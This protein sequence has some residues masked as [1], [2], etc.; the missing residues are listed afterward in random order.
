MHEEP[1]YEEIRKKALELYMTDPAHRNENPSAISDENL[2]LNPKG[3]SCWR[4]AII[5]LSGQTEPAQVQIVS[6]TAIERD[7][8]IRPREA[9]AI[10]G[11]SPETLRLWS[12]KGKIKCIQLP[13]KHRY[14]KSEIEKM[15]GENPEN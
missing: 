2:K 6:T 3:S 10:L 15:K 12:K 13:S 7:K 8:L 4:M 11:V 5:A 14:H 1:T 9:A